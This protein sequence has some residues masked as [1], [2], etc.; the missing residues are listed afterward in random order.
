MIPLH[1][2]ET[3]NNAKRV[4]VMDY[5]VGNLGSLA[6]AFRRLNFRVQLSS[7]P[8]DFSSADA[9]VLPGVGAM[10]LAMHNI[11]NRELD[12]VISELFQDGKIPV[13]G[14]CL[15]MQLM[16]DHSE[17]GDVSGL[18]IIRGQ[19]R[20]FPNALCHVGW[21]I[22]RYPTCNGLHDT[23]AFYF[24]HS[25]Y[26]DTDSSGLDSS[27]NV[28]GHGKIAAIVRSRNFVGMQFHPEKSQAAGVAL[29]RSFIDPQY[30]N[31][32]A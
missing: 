25:Y 16:F 20:R 15:G 23:G 11:R 22:C 13:V 30:G 3:F 14:I 28:E 26:V 7:E 27:V 29:L 18:G 5:G 6:G 9:V 1:N 12:R 32:N 17:E 31:E 24:N 2:G 10:P 21:S 19:V 8:D 4:V